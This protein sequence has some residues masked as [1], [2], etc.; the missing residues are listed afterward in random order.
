M[1]YAAIEVLKRHR[2]MALATLRADGWPQ[3][4]MVSY[5]NLKLRSYFIISRGSQKF[6]NIVRDNRVSIAIGDP[7]VDPKLTYG[8]SMAAR[9]WEVTNP[10]HRDE[11]YRVLTERHPAF[12]G[13][14]FPDWEGAALM[15]AVPQVISIVNFTKGYGHTDA[16]TVGAGDLVLM[17]P[18]RPDDWGFLS[19]S[20]P[21]SLSE[22][23]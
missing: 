13:F 15:Q 19:R 17:E 14:P 11:A 23:S 3:A 2:I 22:S 10:E 21:S 1:E 20:R 16:M 9:V 6:S 8:L 12:K 4:T 5:A 18:A 7:V